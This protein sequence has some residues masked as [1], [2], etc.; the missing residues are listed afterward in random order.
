VLIELRQDQIDTPEGAA[1]W[2]AR[3]ARLLGPIL[4]DGTLYEAARS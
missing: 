1:G 2:A 3:L 4:A